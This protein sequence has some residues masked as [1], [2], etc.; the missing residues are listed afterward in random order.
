MKQPCLGS[1]ESHTNPKRESASVDFCE[2]V[3]HGESRSTANGSSISREKNV[4]NL[5]RKLSFPLQVW[6]APIASCRGT[7]ILVLLPSPLVPRDPP[8]GSVKKNAHFV[9]T[10]G[11][12]KSQRS[13]TY[14]RRVR[15][16]RS[17][18]LA[19]PMAELWFRGRDK[20]RCFWSIDHHRTASR[21]GRCA[22][23]M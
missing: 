19:V 7:A 21:D 20:Q 16:V 12:R 17:L 14:N 6:M 18:C 9:F 3:R 22:E 13:W 11:I 4:G 1:L 2:I 23:A 8:R 10:P 5:D 15:S